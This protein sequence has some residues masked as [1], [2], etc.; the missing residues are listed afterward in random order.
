MEFNNSGQRLKKIRRQLHMKQQ[1]F[2]S[3]GMTRGYYSLIENGKRNLTLDIASKILYKFKKKAEESG[4]KFNIDE[5]YLMMSPR[6]E[7][8]KYCLDNLEDFIIQERVI[9]LI[10]I[11]KKYKLE[12]VQAKIYK[13][14]GDNNYCIRNYFAAFSNYTMSLDFYKNCNY[15]EYIPY[16][17]NR[18]GSCKFLLLEYCEAIM[19]YNRALYYSELYSDNV[20]KRN[21][22]YNIAD[23]YKRQEK[24]NE[25]IIYI[26]TFILEYK[27]SEN[28]REYVYA[29][30]I[31]ANCLSEI[32]NVDDAILI[33]NKLLNEITEIEDS[34]KAYIFNN[35]GTLYLKKE[36][37]LKSLDYFNKSQSIRNEI[38]K[39]NLSHT[40]IDK[41]EVY[42][43]QKL[44][45][46][47][48]MLIN[49]GID[50]AK[51]YNDKEYLLRAYYSLIDMYTLKE[52]YCKIEEIYNNVLLILKDTKDNNNLLKVYMK[53]CEFNFK[54]NNYKKAYEYLEL[55]QSILNINKN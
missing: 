10:D 28:I 26:D 55:S 21:S 5:K 25:A 1:D 2:N 16:L 32:G 53:L 12:E 3:E 29:Q 9:E 13:I 36:E 17:F 44:Y 39:I 35:L 54:K 46:E 31:K 19:Y 37:L 49:L 38:D 6:E 7:A 14:L 27:K 15:K 50:M 24:Y 8:E 48:I 22:I 11:T 42:I 47:A 20:I 30:S 18:L 43:K 52:D 40:L 34:I 45:D 33:Y 41:S 23:C 4:I 51:M